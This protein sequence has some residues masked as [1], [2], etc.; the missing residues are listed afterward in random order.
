MA[1]F[2]VA[3]VF[4]NHMVLQ[5]DKNVKIFGEGEDGQTVTV[6]FRG[7]KAEAV[8]KDGRWCAV[9]APMGASVKGRKRRKIPTLTGICLWGTR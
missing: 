1:E 7:Q 3:A 9:L 4:S 6:E 8:V 5:R 2:S